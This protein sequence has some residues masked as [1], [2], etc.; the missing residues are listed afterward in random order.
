MRPFYR[1]HYAPD[2]ASLV[3]R[4]FL[5]DRQ[6]SYETALVDRTRTGHKAP[7]YLRLNPNGLIPVLETPEG[8]IFETAAILL[9][10]H[11]RHG[12]APEPADAARGDYL[13]WLFFASNTLHADLRVTF[14][15][16]SYIG[17]DPGAQALLVSQMQN[18][19]ARHLATLDAVAGARPAWFDAASP[20]G[21]CWYIACLMRWMALYPRTFD[22][23]WFQLEDTRNLSALLGGLE[24]RPATRAAAAAE[25]LGPRPFTAPQ[26]ASPPEGSAT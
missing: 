26:L 23:S 7:D 25:G 16:A 3:I 6:L 12:F 2:N 19:L 8:A 22:R 17:E 14:Y 9:W 11:D 15:P 5:E 24:G 10:L 1:L 13:K 18:R 21:L 20:S 4:L